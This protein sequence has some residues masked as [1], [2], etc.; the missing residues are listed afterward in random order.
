MDA[1]WVRENDV[2]AGAGPQFRNFNPA[3][4]AART[5]EVPI[6]KS[7]FGAA[8]IEA[9]SSFAAHQRGEN[10]LARVWPNATDREGYRR[11]VKSQGRVASAIVLQ[12]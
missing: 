6:L 2:I 9:G 1:G 12:E 8:R 11:R 4:P 10:E 3:A 7:S 5:P